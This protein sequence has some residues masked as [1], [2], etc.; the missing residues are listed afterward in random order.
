MGALHCIAV[1]VGRL[2]SSSAIECVVHHGQSAVRP[3][4]GVV[5]RVSLSQPDIGATVLATASNDTPWVCVRPADR[6]I[7]ETI[8]NR[9]I[10]TVEY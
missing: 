4:H 1:G 9:P 6:C 2:L 8:E 5:R 10:V 7:S 3:R